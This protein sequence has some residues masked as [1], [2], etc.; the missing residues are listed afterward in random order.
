MSITSNISVDTFNK[1]LVKIIDENHLT[2]AISL[3]KDMVHT[4]FTYA[5][6]GIHPG[7]VIIIRCKGQKG[8]LPVRPFCPLPRMIIP[9]PG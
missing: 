9:I 2:N 6:N 1:T 7:I 5:N 8:I 3:W 4:V